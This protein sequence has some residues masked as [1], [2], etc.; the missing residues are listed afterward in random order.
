[1][2]E[3]VEKL[4]Q[5]V[6]KRRCQSNPSIHQKSA[7]EVC[8]C[9]PLPTVTQTLADQRGSPFLWRASISTL[10]S[11]LTDEFCSHPTGFWMG[12]SL[13]YVFAV[14][15][16]VRSYSSIESLCFFK[17]HLYHCSLALF[18]LIVW[19]ISTA[20]HPIIFLSL[21]TCHQPYGH[22]EFIVFVSNLDLRLS[23][24]PVS[25]PPIPL[26]VVIP[27]ISPHWLSMYCFWAFS[28]VCCR[29]F[30]Y[31]SVGHSLHS[32]H[33]S[34]HYQGSSQKPTTPFIL[35]VVTL[36]WGW[37]V[38]LMNKRGWGAREEREGDTLK[39]SGGGG[40]MVMCVNSMPKIENSG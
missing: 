17:S 3:T 28:W 16:F 10:S 40:V 33:S 29:E 25:S 22:C 18:S 13:F 9:P 6:I 8:L 19:P 7:I 26:F 38:W 37:T 4:G 32:W 24:H 20:A 15:F 2:W 30:P 1:M 14:A 39:D 11:C 23:M 27:F 12:G 31:R 35:L 34:W 5:W 21:F 36:W